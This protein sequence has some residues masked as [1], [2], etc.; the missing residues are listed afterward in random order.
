MYKKF[1]MFGD[2]LS[3]YKEIPVDIDTFVESDYFIGKYTMNGKSIFPYWRNV[4]RKIFDPTNPNLYHEMFNASAI[5]TGKTF[6]SV[7]AF[8]YTLYCHMCVNDL[9]DFLGFAVNDTISFV[10]ASVGNTYTNRLRDCFL[11]CISDS[12]WFNLHGT[13]GKNSYCPIDKRLKI[14]TASKESDIFGVQTV[15][16]LFQWL[17]DKYDNK[18]TYGFYCPVLAR[19]KSRNSKFGK[20]IVDFELSNDYN[21]IGIVTN[22]SSQDDVLITKDSQFM[23]KPQGT[24]DYS[25]SFYVVYD[26]YIG[27]CDIIYHSKPILNNPKA[28]NYLKDKFKFISCPI[29]FLETAKLDV[30]LFLLRVC[31][32]QL[33]QEETTMTFLQAL[34]ELKKGRAIRVDG[35]NR[36]FVIKNDFIY[37]YVLDSN[38]LIGIS[39]TFQE[40]FG[41]DD[42]EYFRSG[43]WIS[44]DAPLK[45]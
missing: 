26:G 11:G 28:S 25:D 20:V 23:I 33:K 29:N 44:F 3:I 30:D 9:N 39:E 40:S 2:D 42:H 31:G 6:I 37:C 12:I 38:K 34:D 35:S 19:I 45:E 21:N 27:H 24:F 43:N 4:L 13:F 22:K 15:G 41:E 16:S 36:Y 17:C 14:I 8:S 5:G 18:N 32:I 7:I 10:I 1:L